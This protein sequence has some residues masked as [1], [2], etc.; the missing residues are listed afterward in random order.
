MAARDPGERTARQMAQAYA[1]AGW[2]VFPLAPG[3]K[4]PAIPGRRAQASA[5]GSATASTTPRPTL[6]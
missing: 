6:A 1:R 3:S 4:L 5:G 2:P